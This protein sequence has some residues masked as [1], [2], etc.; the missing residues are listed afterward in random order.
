M[1]LTE[2][3]K[4][5]R[6]LATNARNRAYHAR[7]SQRRAA[8]EVGLKEINSR[9]DPDIEAASAAED[10][11]RKERDAALTDVDKRISELEDAKKAIQ[12]D[13]ADRY[14]VLRKKMAAIV[15]LRNEEQRLLE[16]SLDARFP[17]L[18]GAARWSAACWKPMDR[19]GE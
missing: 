8:E 11:L 13:F 6:R 16:T 5:R 14:N 15:N 3:E 12:A 10:S 19:E 4:E 2:E 1:A 9:F 18:V 17:D 7:Y